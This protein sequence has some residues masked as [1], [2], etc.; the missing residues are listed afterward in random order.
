MAFRLFDANRH[1]KIELAEHKKTKN[2]YSML[3][4]QMMDGFALHEIICDDAG[5]PIDYRFL[6]V[7][8]AFEKFTGLK[9]EKIIGKTV[10]EVLPETEKYW[11]ELYG[12]VALTGE[13]ISFQNYS[14][15]LRKYYNVKS[16]QPEPN[17]FACVF[18]DI[19]DIVK[20]KEE[21]QRSEERLR[22][23]IKGSSD[24][25]W[26][27]DY[28]EKKIYYSPQWWKQIGYEPDELA[29]SDQLWYELLHHEDKKAV[30][31]ILEKAIKT[32]LQNY[33][34]EF[35][36]RH[37]DGHYV[38]VLSRGFITRNMNGE[39][40]RISGTNTDLT[41]IKKTERALKRK[42]SSVE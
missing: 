29:S 24:A 27:W 38:P 26:D 23:I 12:Q 21:L 2:D 5:T 40:L 31:A 28:S 19:T 4:N 1:V 3:F 34:I 17:Q 37:K 36:L 6:V 42:R 15:P 41:K 35:R 20:T 33:Q 30:D 18:S 14:V 16:F 9:A 39:I 32:D 8:P 13:S 11:I 25:S 22:L 10:L 7:N